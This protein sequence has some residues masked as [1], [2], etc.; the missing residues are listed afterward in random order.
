MIEKT[1]DDS[2]ADI[3]CKVNLLAHGDTAKVDRAKVA[4]EICEAVGALAREVRRLAGE[5]A[6][7]VHDA[8]R[9]PRFVPFAGGEV[10]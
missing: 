8:A 1:I 4:H 2:H 6:V 3:I 5:N 9:A 7:L 10:S